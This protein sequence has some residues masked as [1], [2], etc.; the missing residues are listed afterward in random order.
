M[1]PGNH[2][3]Y[4]HSL[5]LWENL[6]HDLNYNV[7]FSQRAHVVLIHSP[8]ALDAYAR[9]YNTM[10]LTGSDGELWSLEKLKKKIPHL[11]YDNGRFPILGAIVQPLTA[12]NNGLIYEVTTAGTSGSSEPTWPS[13]GTVTDG[14]VT[15]QPIMTGK[16]R[17]MTAVR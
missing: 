7:M 12:Q 6:S 15:W 8:G 2:Q 9:R 16:R 14:G 5:K 13:S 11:N 1:V 3:F 17:Q 4:E 10:K